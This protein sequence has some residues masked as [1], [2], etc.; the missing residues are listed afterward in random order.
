MSRA[1]D[2]EP[3]RLV[4]D[5]SRCDG[6][7]MCAVVCPELI[8]LDRWGFADASRQAI[9]DAVLRRKAARAVRCCPR[10]ALTL[11]AVPDAGRAPGAATMS[12]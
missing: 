10:G 5:A 12:A 7:G 9:S 2:G 8:T 3:V 4:F 1:V 11:S 6:F